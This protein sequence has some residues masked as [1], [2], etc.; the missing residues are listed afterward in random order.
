MARS[1]AGV[2][3][4]KGNSV[5][6]QR[7]AAPCPSLF[8]ALPVRR[9]FPPDIVTLVHY[10]K[11]IPLGVGGTIATISWGSI[12]YRFTVLVHLSSSPALYNGVVA[13]GAGRADTCAI[14]QLSG[15][16]VTCWGSNSNLQLGNSSVGDYSYSPVTVVGVTAASALAVGDQHNCALIYPDPDRGCRSM[17]GLEFPWS[18]GQRH[19]STRG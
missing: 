17:L 4:S 19:N 14:P 12:P 13:I 1:I 5:T 10:C 16:A 6:A 18:I 7:P 3:I 8:L 9:R 15:G 11:T 2:A